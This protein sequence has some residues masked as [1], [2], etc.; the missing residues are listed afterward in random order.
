M[1]TFTMIDDH[2]YCLERPADMRLLHS[3]AH[4]TNEKLD[5][6]NC[7][8][9]SWPFL[10]DKAEIHFLADIQGSQLLGTYLHQVAAL[11]S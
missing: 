2:R 5:V 9:I 6:S 4:S 10:R 8:Q 3:G 11:A 1:S 7:R